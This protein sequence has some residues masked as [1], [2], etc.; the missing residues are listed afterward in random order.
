MR[1]KAICNICNK[2]SRHN[3]KGKCIHCITNK[4]KDKDG[5]V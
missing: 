3:Q 1:R 5:K 4:E 2:K